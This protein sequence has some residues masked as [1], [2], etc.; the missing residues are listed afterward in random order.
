MDNQLFVKPLQCPFISR[1]KKRPFFSR[2]KRCCTRGLQQCILRLKLCD[3]TVT[4]IDIC[5]EISLKE[6]TLF[7]M[8]YFERFDLLALDCLFYTKV[9]GVRVRKSLFDSVIISPCFRNDVRS[10]GNRTCLL[11]I[12][13]KWAISLK[14]NSNTLSQNFLN[15]ATFH[16]CIENRHKFLRRRK[17]TIW[18]H[19]AV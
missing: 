2:N 7:C 19:T 1:I 12:K 6:N 15:T 17:I 18:Q 14:W 16:I 4:K 3:K 9:A 11:L 8:F 13:L 5:V 10:M